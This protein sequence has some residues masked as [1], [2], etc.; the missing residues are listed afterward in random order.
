MFFGRSLKAKG[1]FGDE[2]SYDL[3]YEWHIEIVCVSIVQ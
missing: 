2:N 1:R 3:V